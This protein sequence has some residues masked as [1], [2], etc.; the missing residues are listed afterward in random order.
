MHFKEVFFRRCSVTVH[1]WSRGLAVKHRVIFGIT[2]TKRGHL[3]NFS[4]VRVAVDD[5]I[6][7]ENS[8][9]M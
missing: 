5:G 3:G 1:C 2:I 7:S 4:K 8:V 6:V 9:H